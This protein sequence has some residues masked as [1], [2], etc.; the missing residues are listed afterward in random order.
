MYDSLEASYACG[1][2]GKGWAAT[3]LVALGLRLYVKGDPRRGVELREGACPDT[4]LQN[5]CLA[6]VSELTAGGG[7]IPP[8]GH[9]EACG[10]CLGS[11]YSACGFGVVG[12]YQSSCCHWFRTDCCLHCQLCLAA[13]QP[14]A[15]DADGCVH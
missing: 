14:G 11:F 3:T 1:A 9:T 8:A 13:I 15:E 7:G 2:M 10:K 12:G 5:T 4:Y 6:G